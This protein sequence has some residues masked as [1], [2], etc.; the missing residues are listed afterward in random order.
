MYDLQWT[1]SPK[2]VQCRVVVHGALVVIACAM[3][4]QQLSEWAASF[5]KALL[6]QPCET[7]QFRQFAIKNEKNSIGKWP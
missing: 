7:W 2:R 5:Q 4:P 6:W 3:A 1:L